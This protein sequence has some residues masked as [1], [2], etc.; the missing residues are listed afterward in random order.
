M[1]HFSDTLR[2]RVVLNKGNT[3]VFQ[4]FCC[5]GCT[6]IIICRIESLYPVIHSI[7]NTTW[8]RRSRS[9]GSC[10]D[11][12]LPL[13]SYVC[14]VPRVEPHAHHKEQQ[15]DH[16][17]S[18]DNYRSSI[19]VCGMHKT[20]WLNL[21]LWIRTRCISRVKWLIFVS[22]FSGSSNPQRVGV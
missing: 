6:E 11:S 1:I 5:V 4:T 14:Q 15:N 16:Q 19:I 8:N 17:C 18:Q 10:V 7:V 2:S 9:Q 20:S 13:T 12:R 22:H 21:P 3:L